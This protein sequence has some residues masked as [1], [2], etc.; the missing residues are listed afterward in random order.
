MICDPHQKLFGWWN[1]GGLCSRRGKK[2]N[3]RGVLVGKPEEK[4]SRG[5]PMPWLERNIKMDLK[6]IEWQKVDLIDVA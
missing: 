4:R 3:T 5:L 6:C 2:R 1:Q